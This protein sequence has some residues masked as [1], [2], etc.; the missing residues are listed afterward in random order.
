MTLNVIVTRA[1]PG[2]HDTEAA[3]LQLGFIPLLSPMLELAAVDVDLAA[4]KAARHIVFTS[5]NGVRAIDR[6]AFPDGA[7]IWCVGPSTARA[8]EHAFPLRFIME[9]DGNSDDLARKIIQRIP[10]PEG[11]FVHIANEDAAGR[12]VEQLRHAGFEVDFLAPYRTIAAPALS[13]QALSAL[14]GKQPA[15]VLIHSAKAAEALAATQPN[16]T[17]AALVAISEAALAPLTGLPNLGTWTARKP[18]ESELLHIL[19]QAAAE[20]AH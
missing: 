19:A 5:A 11:R 18:N 17:N 16:L 20:I 14:A 15:A 9:G 7:T 3:L 6:L 8:A 13:E 1:E 2:A 4:L 10:R 12:L